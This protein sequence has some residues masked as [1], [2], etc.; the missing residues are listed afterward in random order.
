MPWWLAGLLAVGLGWLAKSVGAYLDDKIID[1]W[2][3]E[4]TATLD[5]PY[6]IGDRWAPAPAWTG[7][8]LG[9]IYLA[10]LAVPWWISRALLRRARVDPVFRARLRLRVLLVC[11]AL[12][13]VGALAFYGAS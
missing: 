2:I 6:S 10:I 13:I 11:L 1:A 4:Q 7:G 9:F 12:A 3:A 5:N 8:V